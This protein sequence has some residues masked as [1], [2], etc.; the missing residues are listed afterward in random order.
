MTKIT[1]TDCLGSIQGDFHWSEAREK[2]VNVMHMFIYFQ[3]SSTQA[4]FF[5]QLNVIFVAF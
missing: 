2:H 4:I 5:A 3:G 1:H